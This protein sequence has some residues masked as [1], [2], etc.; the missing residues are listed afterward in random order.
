MARF[1]V[2]S[3]QPTLFGQTSLVRNWGRIGTSGRE[4]IEQFE[5]PDGAAAALSKLA[6]R[7]IKRGYVVR[8]R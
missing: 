1:Y 5:T 2:L 7:K 4:K 8:G 6:V 3:L